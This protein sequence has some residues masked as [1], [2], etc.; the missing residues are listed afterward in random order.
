MG[1]VLWDDKAVEF[2][3]EELWA[4]REWV[5]HNLSLC[6]CWSIA[7]DGIRKIETHR[8]YIWYFEQ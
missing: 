8:D 3:V 5:I 6:M 4:T 2:T 1:L 7:Y